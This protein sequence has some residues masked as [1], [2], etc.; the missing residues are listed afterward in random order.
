MLHAVASV[1]Y[2]LLTNAR[3]KCWRVIATAGQLLEINYD[4]PDL[5]ITDPVKKAIQDGES[6]KLVPHEAFEAHKAKQAAEQEATMAA[7]GM[8]GRW[9]RRMQDKLEG[10]ANVNLQG[11]IVSIIARGGA[12]AMNIMR[13]LRNGF[14]AEER[15]RAEEEAPVSRSSIDRMRK[16]LEAKQ[17]VIKFPIKVVDGEIDVCIQSFSATEEEPSRVG[18]YVVLKD[19]VEKLGLDDDSQQA[20]D[21]GK[22]TDPALQHTVVKKEMTRLERDIGTLSNRVQTLTSGAEFNKQ[23][24]ISFFEKSMAMN[25]ASTYWPIIQLTVLVVAGVAQANHIVRYMKTKRIM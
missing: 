3:P 23:Y 15:G 7:Y 9:N 2:S 22:E 25:K 17:G 10:M 19:E 6:E 4:V 1:P 24:E 20:T 11:T 14:G 13:P 12:S 21:G 16:E 8:D 5:K 18:L